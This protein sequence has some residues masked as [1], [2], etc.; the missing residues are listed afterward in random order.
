MM[1]SVYS[2]VLCQDDVHIQ[3]SLL[4]SNLIRFLHICLLVEA[5][6]SLSQ[7]ASY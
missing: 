4:L 2:D 1:H 5:A 3:I 7:G 6:N